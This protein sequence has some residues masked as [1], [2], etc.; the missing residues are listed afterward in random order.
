MTKTHAVASLSSQSSLFLS[1]L[2]MASAGLFAQETICYPLAENFNA[3]SSGVVTLE[4]LANSSGQTGDFISTSVPS[5]LCPDNGQMP[6]YRFEDNAGLGFDNSEGFIDC[7]Y[8]AEFTVNFEQLPASTFFETPW[9]WVL[10]TTAADEGLFIWRDVLFG[11]FYL[12]FWEGNNRLKSV[13]MEDFNTSDWYHFTVTRDCNGQIEVYLNCTFFTD[14]DDSN[15]GILRMGAD[16]GNKMVFFQDDPSVLE[17][18]ASPGK[19]RNIRISNYAI[20]AQE[21]AERCDCLC[22]SMSSTC[23]VE[24]TL[25]HTTCLP[26]EAGTFRDTFP[27]ASRFC[28]CACDSIVTTVVTLSPE[29]DCTGICTDTLQ[30]DTMLCAGD[31]FLSGPVERDTVL[32]APGPSGGDCDTIWRYS[33]RALSVEPASIEANICGGERYVFGDTTLTTS[34]TYTRTFSSAAGCDSTVT[35]QLR[36]PEMPVDTQRQQIC[37]GASFLGTTILRDTLICRT[38]TAVSGCD[39]TV[40]YQLEAI[41]VARTEIEAGICPGENFA[42]GDTSFSSQG[43]YTLRFATAEGC[44]SL[45][46]LRLQELGGELSAKD[47]SLCAGTF[48]RGVPI[49]RDTSF[50]EI[51]ENESGCR[52][53]VLYRVQVRPIIRDTVQAVICPGETYIFGDTTLAQTGSYTKSFT[54]ANGCDSL[55]T[56]ELRLRETPG[57][58]ITGDAILCA[59]EPGRLDAGAGF[60]NYDWNDGMATGRLLEIDDSGVYAVTVVDGNGCRDSARVEV[61]VSPEILIDFNINQLESC[62]G[63]RDGAVSVLIS[64]GT[65]PFTDFEWSGGLQ[66]NPAFEVTA[67]R[68]DLT[69]TD[70]LGCSA[71][72]ALDFPAPETFDLEIIAGNPVCP[73][74]ADG[75]LRIAVQ[76]DTG[77]Y[78]YALDGGSFQSDSVFNNLDDG[79]Y[80]VRVQD[81][82]GCIETRTVALDAPEP[83]DLSVTPAE[84]RIAAGESVQ[85]TTTTSLDSP[86]SIRWTPAASLDCDSCRVVTAAPVETTAYSVRIMDEN[87]C[88]LSAEALVEVM[89]ADTLGSHSLFVPNAFSPNGDGVND[90]L[91][92]FTG[93]EIVE[94]RAFR[95]FSR[96]G[97]LVHERSAFLPGDSRAAW[98]GTVSGRAADASTYIWTCK[99]VYKNTE[100]RQESGSVLLI[101]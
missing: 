101:R 21:V 43:T 76:G 45:V 58:Q 2:C 72:A 85:L 36:V 90:R 84:T 32:F 35:L 47:T 98:D 95:I 39:S 41:P 25:E 51:R 86:A 6:A 53:S 96:W 81:I 73:G 14:F 30:V 27:V 79:A 88:A 17:G 13:A 37:A 22:E 69:V 49:L 89:P 65:P 91:E 24:T 100:T 75:S 29:S 31:F 48:F 26:E 44:D 52:D 60:T 68:Y 40:C 94:V 87:G 7:A 80:E 83:F 3:G 97:S 19:V 55:V 82:N 62:P 46:T 16:R 54:A 28:G 9:I 20:P 61:T 10:G 77:P 1:L 74:A 71:T 5:N 50:L 64:G 57:V 56:L 33:I 34:G 18:D 67:G 12:E 78:L 4:P 8:T 38:R 66:G 15:Y 59:G 11:G 70:S 93:K 99:V 63:A 23:S 92:V 42:I